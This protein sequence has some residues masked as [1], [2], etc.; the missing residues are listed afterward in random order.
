[1]RMPSAALFAGNRNFSEGALMRRKRD[2]G[3]ITVLLAVVGVSVF[4]VS[5][6]AISQ[7]EKV[8]YSFSGSF[9]DPPSGVIF[10]ASGALY[11]T[12]FGG[13]TGSVAFE[14][15]ASEGGVWTESILDDLPNGTYLE[16]A[17]PLLGDASGNLYGT[18]AGGGESGGGNVFEL[19]PAIGG[20]WTQTILYSFDRNTKD[21]YFPLGG[22][23]FDV[24]GNIYGVTEWG[25]TSGNGT[26]F[27]LTPSGGGS[28]SEKI[29]HSFSSSGED[30]NNPEAVL[31][32][33]SAGNLYGTTTYGG[34]GYGTVFELTP[35]SG[36]RWTEKILHRFSN[37]GKDGFWPASGL[38]FDA[39]GN[40]YGVTPWGWVFGTTTSPGGTVFQLSPSA[41]GG[42]AE[43]IIHN[44]GN[45]GNGTTAF[46]VIVDSSGNLYGS[47]ISGGAFNYGAVFELS[48]STDGI[49]TER[50][51][52]S[53][54]DNAS[55]DG[56]QPWAV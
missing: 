33:D 3:L 18:T 53:F 29:L 37:N 1:M 9:A 28:F 44:F 26:V 21:G 13:T 45:G 24:A 4:A 27:Q 30:G 23:I 15:A 50:T 41:N 55:N 56:A 12:V 47:T 46:G 14:L 34:T 16:S 25:G 39:H 2:S 31:T 40:L 35:S 20:T 8:L 42:W 19:T 49:W 54:H 36:G 5:T 17:S 11:G 52:Y 6:P 7:T 51:I 38:V 32:I 48:P 43:K 22:I 10:G